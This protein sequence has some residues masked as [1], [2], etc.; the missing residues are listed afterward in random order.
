MSRAECVLKVDGMVC[1]ACA[2]RVRTVAKRVN[3]VGAAVVS[4]TDGTAHITYDSAK[5]DPIAIAQVV[6]QA[7]GFKAEVTK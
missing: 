5:T 2:T 1:G 6:T 3:G 4:Y 7:A